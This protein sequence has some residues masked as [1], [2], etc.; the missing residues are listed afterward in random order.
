VRISVSSSKAF[1]LFSMAFAQVCALKVV[2]A[3][4]VDGLTEVGA[5]W[6]DGRVGEGGKGGAVRAD[7]VKGYGF[8]WVVPEA[9]VLDPYPGEQ[10]KMATRIF[11][12]RL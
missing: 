6:R 5:G 10:L 2:D 1:L 11:S 3:L 7:V 8:S 9:A 4:V 12:G